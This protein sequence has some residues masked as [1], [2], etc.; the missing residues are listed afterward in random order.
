MFSFLKDKIKKWTKKVHKEKA[1]PIEAPKKIQKNEAVK[2]KVKEIKVPLKFNPADKTFQP[3]TEKLEEIKNSN[4]SSLPSSFKQRAIPQKKDYTSFEKDY[5]KR[6]DE[7]SPT[8]N[9]PGTQKIDDRHN[10]IIATIIKDSNTKSRGRTSWECCKYKKDSDGNVY[11]TEF[12][13]F[14]G[15]EKCKRATE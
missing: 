12:H 13:S 8:G 7:R 5:I 11:C 9:T 14:C 3:D 1:T 15:K 6:A 10:N 2:K 4:K